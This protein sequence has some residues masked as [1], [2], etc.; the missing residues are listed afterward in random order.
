MNLNTS[1]RNFVGALRTTTTNCR[2][3]FIDLKLVFP[4]N[5]RVVFLSHANTVISLEPYC[6]PAVALRRI[7]F[8]PF[9]IISYEFVKIWWRR[10]SSWERSFVSITDAMFY[11]G[12]VVCVPVHFFS[13]PL[14]FTVVA[15]SIS[16]FL[17]A[18]IK[19]SC[20]SSNETRVPCFLFLAHALSLL[21]TLI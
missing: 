20:F 4:T 2:V 11:G 15:I 7:D 9:W 10:L 12:N 13:L 17:T 6:G 16:H 3:S 14:I 8:R 1:S 19:S 21:F 5:F 18:G